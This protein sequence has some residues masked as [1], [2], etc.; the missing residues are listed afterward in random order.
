MDSTAI[1]R[2]QLFTATVGGQ[3]KV[4]TNVVAAATSSGTDQGS[5]QCTTARYCMQLVQ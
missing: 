2:P 3:P 1:H 5:F 4:H